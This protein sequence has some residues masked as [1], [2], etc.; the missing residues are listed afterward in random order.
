[1]AHNY[2]FSQSTQG[3]NVQ[4]ET[5]LS[6]G[7]GSSFQGVGLSD[8]FWSATGTHTFSATYDIDPGTATIALSYTSEGDTVTNIPTNVASDFPLPNGL[9]VNSGNALFLDGFYGDGTQGAVLEFTNH[10]GFTLPLLANL[11]GVYATFFDADQALYNTYLAQVRQAVIGQIETLNAQN[12]ASVG[13]IEMTAWD[14]GDGAN[15]T[16]HLVYTP[17]ANTT[18]TVGDMSFN[19]YSGFDLN[20]F[21]TGYGYLGQFHQ[22]TGQQFYQG[23]DITVTLTD[24]NDN[25]TNFR[26]MGA[27]DSLVD[28]GGGD[29]YVSLS[30]D[31]GTEAAFVD[32]LTLQGGIGNDTLAASVGEASATQINLHG[33]VGDDF[34][35]AYSLNLPS[36]STAFLD[37]GE[38]NDNL[39]G[40]DQ[41]QSTLHGGTGNDTLRG[42]D[43]IDELDGGDG[44]DFI[45][46]RGGND[47]IKGGAGNDSIYGGSGDDAL[48][49]GTGDDYLDGGDGINTASYGSADAG[50]SVYLK[51]SG[52]ETGQG[53]DSFFLIQNLE[54]SDYADR[55]T[56][57][58][59][60]NALTGG[61]GNDT[62]R[63]QGGEDRLDGGDGADNLRS[64][65]ENDTL[66]GR[67]GDDILVA[68]DGN[69]Q[70]GSGGGNDFAYGGRGDDT[71]NGNSGEDNIRGNRGND[72]LDGGADTDI[73]RGG[74]G[75]DTVIGS[76]GDDFLF[77]ENGADRIEGGDGNDVMRGGISGS[78]GDGFADVFVFTAGDDFDAIKDFEN[79][80]DAIDLT[81]FGFASFAQ[82]EALAEDRPSGL[83]IDFGGGDVLFIDNLLLAQFDAGD[84][85]LA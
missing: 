33:G 61:T 69:D 41:E 19:D 22:F 40:L 32:T 43:R 48:D 2:D 68:L 78:A 26:S 62:L 7:S 52:R 46:A 67:D 14:N 80:T 10:T 6:N 74:G 20:S 66:L 11:T 38:G 77:G 3:V 55:L 31:P 47:L 23:S 13:P 71:I 79:G 15:P 70:I 56:G 5:L 57:D 24:H 59:S 1:M 83:R 29:D 18:R 82:V 53:Q 81:D 58:E 63:G 36:V 12:L 50:V 34:L 35:S 42:G 65:N 4:L 72:V 49:A 37:G 9:S 21:S 16:Y 64:G 76:F 30:V 60:A 44:A 8:H 84:V 73:I 28:G 45:Q 25:M 54:G 85:V 17:D 75:N 51:Y 27:D 39:T